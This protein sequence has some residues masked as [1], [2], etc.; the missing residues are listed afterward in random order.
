MRVAAA[1]Q[2]K[3]EGENQP[4]K[5]KVDPAEVKQKIRKTKESKEK[6]LKDSI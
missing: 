4:K 1:K 3:E 5:K 2:K 6:Q